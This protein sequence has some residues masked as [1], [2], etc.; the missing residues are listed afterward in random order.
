MTPADRVDM[1]RRQLHDA[2]L[3]DPRSAPTRL[4]TLLGQPPTWLWTL[5][6]VDLLR[7]LPGVDDGTA[8]AIMEAARCAPHGTVAALKPAERA[9]LRDA[10]ARHAGRPCVRIVAPD[11]LCP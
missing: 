3:A 9:R 6:T 11:R 2:L 8:A 4:A 5:R 7:L 10:L 1:A